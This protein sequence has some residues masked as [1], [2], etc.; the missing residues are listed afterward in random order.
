MSFEVITTRVVTGH[1]VS[2]HRYGGVHFNNNFHDSMPDDFQ[3]KSYKC[4]T[5]REFEQL[6]R[7]FES[8]IGAKK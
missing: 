8:V 1:T 5:V 2:W 6:C 4:K 7:I 3:G